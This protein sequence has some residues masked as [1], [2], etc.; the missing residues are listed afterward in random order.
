MRLDGGKILHPRRHGQRFK[1]GGETLLILTAD[2][3]GPVS[4]AYVGNE[5]FQR[6][7]TPVVVENTA[8]LFMDMAFGAG[9]GDD[10]VVQAKAL[11]SA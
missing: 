8:A 11:T 9:S 6:G 1:E 10:A 3:L 5:A 4:P 7:Q 2:D